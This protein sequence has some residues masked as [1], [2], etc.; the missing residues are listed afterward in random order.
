MAH[1]LRAGGSAACNIALV[2]TGGL[3]MYWEI[4]VRLSYARWVTRDSAVRQR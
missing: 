4:G 1:S 3:D 2:A